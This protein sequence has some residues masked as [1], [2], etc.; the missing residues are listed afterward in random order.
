MDNS[1]INHS[2]IVMMS[3]PS[4]MGGLEVQ[5]KEGQDVEVRDT[6]PRKIPTAVLM[7]GISAAARG[8]RRA[9]KRGGFRRWGE[10]R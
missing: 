10:R 4:D 1:G 2:D 7:F 9:E 6:C 5:G 3:D 8:G